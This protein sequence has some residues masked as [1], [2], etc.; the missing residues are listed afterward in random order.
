MHDEAIWSD[1][2][3]EAAATPPPIDAQ[4]FREWMSGQGVFV[5]SVMDDE[6]RPAREAVRSWV[7][8]AGGTPV[9]WEELAPRDQHPRRAYLEGVDRSSIYVLLAG[10]SYGVQDSTGFSPTHQE[11]ERAKERSIPR[12]LMESTDVPRQQRDG[13]LNRGSARCTTRLQGLS[14][15]PSKILLI[16]WRPA[17]ARW[18]ASRRRRGSNSD[19]SYFPVAWHG[20]EGIK[21]KSRS[22]VGCERAP[23]DGRFPS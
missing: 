22:Q 2:I 17:C 11:G 21:V 18:R 10:T 4:R 1:L 13:Y 8:A 3:I 16:P 23:S 12:L 14:M 6:M 20:V 9:M 15:H 7:R 19:S 5:S